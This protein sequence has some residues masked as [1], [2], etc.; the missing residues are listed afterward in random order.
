M[1]PLATSSRAVRGLMTLLTNAFRH[2]S[3]SIS[4]RL[5]AVRLINPQHLNRD[6]TQPD[7]RPTKKM[8]ESIIIEHT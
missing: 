4:A 1:T 2:R 3:D 7:V 8:M 5:E 6:D